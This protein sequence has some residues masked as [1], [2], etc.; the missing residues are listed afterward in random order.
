M[1]YFGDIVKIDNHIAE[2]KAQQEEV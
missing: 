2:L 1:Y